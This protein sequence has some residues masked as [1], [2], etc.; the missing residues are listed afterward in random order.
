MVC[1]E[2]VIFCA[3]ISS[4]LLN[5]SPQKRPNAV[6]HQIWQDVGSDWEWHVCKYYGYPSR[7]FSKGS[8][9]QSKKYTF[10]DLEN[11]SIKT[12]LMGRLTSKVLGMLISFFSKNR[13]SFWKNR[14]FSIIEFVRRSLFNATISGVVLTYCAALTQRTYRPSEAAA[15]RTYGTD[16]QIADGRT[17]VFRIR[18]RIADP[19]LTLPY[20]RG[21][22]VLAAQRWGRICSAQCA[23]PM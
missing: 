22:Q 13:F 12:F 3:C 1:Q 9:K 17:R 20:L 8:E 6:W 7:G 14:F 16:V 23:S 10:L 19:Y 4:F 2:A 21:G 15:T 5:E 11:F 18:G